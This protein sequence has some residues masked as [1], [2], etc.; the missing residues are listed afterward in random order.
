[1]GVP[2]SE[3]SAQIEQA[4]SQVFGADT[5]VRSLGIGRHGSGFAYVAVCGLQI[6]NADDDQRTGVV[7]GGHI[8]VGTLGCFVRL[9]AGGLAILSNN[10]WLRLRR[11]EIQKQSDRPGEI[12]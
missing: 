12:Q 9:A 8:I 2:F 11:A 5:R 1:M 4:A 3:A 6:E 10:M 7:A